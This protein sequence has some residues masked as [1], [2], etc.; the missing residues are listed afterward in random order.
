[1]SSHIVCVS[2]EYPWP[3]GKAPWLIQN[4]GTGVVPPLPERKKE[5]KPPAASERKEGKPNGT[6]WRRIRHSQVRSP[7]STEEAVKMI[8]LAGRMLELGMETRGA[9]STDT[10]ILKVSTGVVLN[11]LL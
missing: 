2:Q 8:M 3:S 6:E 5:V 11:S 9:S 7:P 1:M 4:G 10:N